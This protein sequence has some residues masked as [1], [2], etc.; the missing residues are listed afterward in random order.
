MRDAVDEALLRTM[1]ADDA[2]RSNGVPASGDGQP[3]QRPLRRSQLRQPILAEMIARVLRDRIVS[4]ELRDAD[5][6][7]K[8]EELI[9]EFQVS[10]PSMREALRILEAEGLITVRRGNI[11]GAVVHAPKAE[12][13]AF[14]LGLVLQSRHVRL[15]DLAGALQQLE[16]LC[17]SLCALRED[18]GTQVVPALRETV[19][20]TA[21]WIDDPVHFTQLSRQFHERV[22]ARCGNETLRL[23]VGTLESLWSGH[24]ESWAE[25]AEVRGAYPATELRTSVLR[26]HRRILEAIEAGDRAE[27]TRVSREHLGKS[28]LYALTDQDLLVVASK[29]QMR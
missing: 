5:M 20:A 29:A 27:A 25:R 9:D 11:G 24:E 2:T 26:A 13:A 7:P 1:D 28:Q 17:A 12:S 21:E 6:L 18:R 19:E 10:K 23:I 4:G 3:A 14:M 16:P 22:V 15:T 8:Q